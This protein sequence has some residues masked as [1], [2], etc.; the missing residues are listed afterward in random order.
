MFSGVPQGTLPALL[1][2]LLFI[3]DIG[4]NLTSHIRLFTDDCQLFRII[5]SVTNT[6]T[7]KTDLCKMS[8]WAW[9]WQMIFNPEKSYTFHMYKTPNPLKM[10][11]VMECV[12]LKA[13]SH[14]PY[15]GVELQRDLKWKTHIDDITSKA[16]KISG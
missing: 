3:N 5:D 6:V 14:H 7:L 1:I 15:L 12:T 11:H 13:V 9:K 4:E 8:L 16:N 10:D 2:F